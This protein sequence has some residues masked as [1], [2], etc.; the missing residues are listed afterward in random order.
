MVYTI[1]KFHLNSLWGNVGVINRCRDVLFVRVIAVVIVIEVVVKV[2]AVVEAGR[3]Q[4]GIDMVLWDRG[5][6]IS[7]V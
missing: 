3:G 5:S 4:R 2:V 6:G 1:Y 7:V